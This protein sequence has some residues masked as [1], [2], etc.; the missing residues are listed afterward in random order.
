M[1]VVRTY[2]CPDCGGSFDF[3]HMTRDE[4]P[5]AHCELCRTFMGEVEPELP[6]VNI[7]GSNISKSVDQVY[8]DAERTMGVTDWND[9][10]R[11]GDATAKKRQLPDNEVTRFAA[12][13]GMNLWG[14]ASTSDYV[15]A[16]G[17]RRNP[18]GTGAG[19]IG[20]MQEKNYGRR[21]V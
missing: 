7:G 10:L 9:G 19:V 3:L 16:A 21:I 4:P 8:R 17:A 18:E 20:A 2:G 5:P 11:D 6:G 14:G 12:Q 15:K 1:P 13:N